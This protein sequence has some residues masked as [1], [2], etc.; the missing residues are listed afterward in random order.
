MYNLER[1]TS[2]V[3]FY[4]FIPCPLLFKSYFS[5]WGLREF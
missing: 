1:T 4:E 5:H 2:V 3:Q